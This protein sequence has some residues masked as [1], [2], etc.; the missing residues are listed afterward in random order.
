MAQPDFHKNLY[1]NLDEYITNNYTFE[2]KA[3]LVS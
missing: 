2:F 3:K 1:K